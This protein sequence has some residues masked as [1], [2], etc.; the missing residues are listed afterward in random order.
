MLSCLR[1]SP[2]KQGTLDTFFKR[3]GKAAVIDLLLS[4]EDEPGSAA[5]G[6][7][8]KMGTAG[9]GL[10][11]ILSGLGGSATTA[12][13]S[14][15]GGGGMAGLASA[16]MGGGGAAALGPAIVA[17]LPLIAALIAALIV[18]AGVGF[19]IGAVT[20]FTDQVSFFHYS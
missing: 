8:S 14:A 3:Q 6:S 12:A 19:A 18:L 10:S 11:G 2:K 15:G 5:A 16:L 9:K 20:A 13:G 17:A 1:S 7:M 4:D